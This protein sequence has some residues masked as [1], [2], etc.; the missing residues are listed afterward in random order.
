MNLKLML[1]VIAVGALV[2]VGERL[3]GADGSPGVVMLRGNYRSTAPLS[4]TGPNGEYR[5]TTMYDIGVRPTVTL[6]RVEL[7]ARKE[8]LVFDQPVATSPAIPPPAVSRP[9]VPCPTVFQPVVQYHPARHLPMLVPGIV[10][11]YKGGMIIGGPLGG[12]ILPGEDGGMI[13]GGP[14]GG[15]ILPGRKGGMI[16]GGPLGGTILPGDR[17]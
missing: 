11:S 16:I 3:D 6:R 5:R 8:Q 13:I 2:C 4:R 7:P 1:L 10:P 12:T 15:T 9:A 17:R 14:L